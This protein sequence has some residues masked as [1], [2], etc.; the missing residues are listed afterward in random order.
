MD[1][2]SNTSNHLIDDSGVH[3]NLKHTHATLFI[4]FCRLITIF[5]LAI[6]LVALV[7]GNI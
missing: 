1:D 5:L 4:L 6:G 3:R 7:V 2:K